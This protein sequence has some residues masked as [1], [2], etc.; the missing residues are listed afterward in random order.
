MQLNGSFMPSRKP[1]NRSNSSLTAEEMQKCI[2]ILQALRPKF[3]ALQMQPKIDYP[4]LES[5]TNR[6]RT[7]VIDL[8]GAQ[9]QQSQRY[10]DWRPAYTQM[11]FGD[12]PDYEVEQRAQKA[13]QEGVIR[14]LTELDSVVEHLS[15]NLEHQGV[16]K[17]TTSGELKLAIQLCERLNQSAK[18]L[19]R[20]RVD[21][22][23][24]QIEDEYDVQDLLKAILRA[25]FK[26][27]VSEDPISKVAGVSSR[28]DFAIE[29]LGL[30]L[31]VKF[32]RSPGEQARIVKEFAEDLL[33]YSK[34]QFL[35]H[36]IY[37]VYGADDLNEPELLDKLQG[38]QMINGKR[39][40]AYIV[41][42]SS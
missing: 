42:C 41:R 12:E 29:E 23:P 39:F 15:L 26:Y 13:Y 21:K 20:R 9:T 7:T 14:T 34:C 17:F 3:V 40:E 24:F 5:L 18:V 31:E 6:F 32:V 2:S 22:K 35:E 10:E 19:A 1:Q 38:A 16:S 30:I 33:F 4:V 36:F 27:V 8:H 37:F 25:Y 11:F 28:A